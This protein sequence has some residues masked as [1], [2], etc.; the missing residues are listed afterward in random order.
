[1]ASIG[2]QSAIVESPSPILLFI[3]HF[4]LENHTLFNFFL[5]WLLRFLKMVR[6]SLNWFLQSAIVTIF[7]PTPSIL[8]IFHFIFK[9]HT[10]CN[11]FLVGLLRFL[12]KSAKCLQ[13]L[14]SSHQASFSSFQVKN[15]R[16]GKLALSYSN[17]AASA[18]LNINTVTPSHQKRRD[19]PES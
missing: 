2:S 13:L 3:F 8:L 4:I 9:N 18:R 10:L 19:T 17:N 1:M 6:D 14:Q 12:K 11:F 16:W 7:P 15:P 5:V